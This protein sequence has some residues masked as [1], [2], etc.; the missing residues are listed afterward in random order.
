MKLEIHIGEYIDAETGVKKPKEV[1][2]ITEEQSWIILQF[3][4]TRKDADMNTIFKLNDVEFK[5]VPHI[6][7]MANA[8]YE[9]IPKRP[10]PS[11][12]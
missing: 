10:N 5:M 9:T 7:T 3:A 1:M 2:I 11:K 12:Q 4:S 8:V 6:E